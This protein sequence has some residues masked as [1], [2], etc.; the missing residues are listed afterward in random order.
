MRWNGVFVL[1]LGLTTLGF[2]AVLAIHA[3][4]PPV[5]GADGLSVATLALGA[6][7]ACIGTL[8]GRPG[9]ASSFRR[10]RGARLFAGSSQSGTRG[11][12]FG[13]RAAYGTLPPVPSK[14][15][16]TKIEYKPHGEAKQKPQPPE[17]RLAIEGSRSG[18]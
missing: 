6:I 4:G 11:R 12:N 2:V 8:L 9:S 14:T 1:G 10:R 5:R 13:Q 17:K 16:R 18:S 15:A 3:F 7:V